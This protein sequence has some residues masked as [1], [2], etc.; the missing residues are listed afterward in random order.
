MNRREGFHHKQL[1]HPHRTRH[2]YATDIVAHQIDNHHILGAI[3]WRSCKAGGLFS[4]RLR[5]RKTR[6]RAFNRAG[7]NLITRQANKT[8]RRQAEDRPLRKTQE[9]TERRAILT[10]Q[11][12]KRLPLIAA[13]ARLKTL[14]E[15]DLIAVAAAQPGL[16]LAELL[17]ILRAAHIG[18]PGGG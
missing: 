10:I 3:F 18:L 17:A 7:F 4:I 15:V 6:Q 2:R 11:A 9:G 5:I 12:H 16:H 14:C 13:I 8:L 1:R